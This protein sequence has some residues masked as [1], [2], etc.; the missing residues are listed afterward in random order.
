MRNDTCSIVLISL[1]VAITHSRTWFESFGWLMI[2]LIHIGTSRYELRSNC[3]K[4]IEFIAPNRSI[5]KRKDVAA[6]EIRIVHTLH[7]F[8]VMQISKQQIE[9]LK[10]WWFIINSSATRTR[11]TDN[12][13]CKSLQRDSDVILIFIAFVHY[14]NSLFSMPSVGSTVIYRRNHDSKWRRQQQYF[15]CDRAID[16]LIDWNLI[17][18]IDFRTNCNRSFQWKQST[19]FPSYLNQL[20]FF[21][22]WFFN[23]FSYGWWAHNDQTLGI[24]PS[25]RN[26]QLLLC[27]PSVPSDLPN[28][29]Y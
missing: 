2:S 18:F 7:G 19:S 26:V 4:S 17:C 29:K 8:K 21:F 10:L 22:K 20:I 1:L 24:T 25:N 28:A 6:L 14:E 9:S 12:F 3:T 13:S 11:T 5:W 15:D 27:A 16:S 23:G